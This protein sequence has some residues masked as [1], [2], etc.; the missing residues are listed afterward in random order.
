MSAGKPAPDNTAL[1]LFNRALQHQNANRMAEA[2]ELYKQ[3]L[4]T[5][6]NHAHTL[7]MLGF[8]AYNTGRN[9]EAEQLVRKAIAA[10]GDVPMFYFTLG[11]IL[12][13]GKKLDEAI[14]NYRQALAMKP[15]FS[16]CHVNLGFSLQ[17]Q[18]K[19]KESRSCFEKAI[20]YKPDN[21]AAYFGLA[22]LLR[23]KKEYPEALHYFRQAAAI[24]PD[25]PTFANI[26]FI[27]QEHGQLEEALAA[28][29]K[30]NELA[31]GT[32][33]VL[34][35]IGIVNNELG[36]YEEALT[37]FHQAL[38]LKPRDEEVLSNTA[39]ALK[40]LGKLD[41]A[42]P[43]YRKALEIAPDHPGIYSNLLLA[44]IYASS[45]SPEELAETSRGFGIRIADPLRRQ[46]PFKNDK[47]PDRKL[48]IGYVSPDFCEHPVDYF[49]GHLLTLQDKENFE[50]FAYSNTL[51]YDA[52]TQRLQ[53]E[54]DHWR[55]IQI[56]SDD[57]AADLIE[58][59]KIDILVDLA[60]HTGRNR[61]L[62]FARKPAPL[63]VTW[64]GHPATTGMLAMDYRL[65]DPYAEPEGMTEDFN[66]ET[67]WRLPDIFCCYR[68]QENSPA[69]IDHPPFKDNG[70]VTFGCFNNFAKVTDPV[71]ETWSRIMQQVPDARLLL[72]ITGIDDPKPRKDV[73]ERLVK[74]GL[75]LDRV[76]LEPR[77]RSNQFVLYNRIDIALDPFPCCGGTTSFDTMWM[78]VPLV[79]LAGRHFVSRM[80][81]SILTNAGM[82]ELIAK[83]TDEY[84][85]IATTLA[86]DR[87]RLKKLRHNLRDKVA[88]SPVMDQE[89]FTRAME[90][91]YRE[92]WR[93]YIS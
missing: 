73:E 29:K 67:L 35:N 75:P 24:K 16:D 86:Q 44:M 25:G 51:K 32:S 69:V 11:N 81:V 83:N 89:R 18:K 3:I 80:G 74:F 8:I 61:L 4:Q 36:R 71:L 93:R 9:D 72:E 55:D 76:I 7:H 17:E 15:E 34:N 43:Y 60:G 2:E 42:I 56:L 49:F 6:P 21:P 54:A 37:Y 26:A 45:V 14:E 57:E 12:K 79:T 5:D 59:D 38:A 31:P 46:R 10:R 90:N 33:V 66:V 91:A 87:A 88:T 64:L 23:D 92:M 53:R 27:L 78:G 70:Y 41:E 65:T 30:A 68:P 84:I 39:L 22:G 77:K 47:T 85:S 52:V 50:T 48:R 63:Q 19:Y 1:D 28:Y 20:K 40:N 82:P 58:K 13:T 62:V